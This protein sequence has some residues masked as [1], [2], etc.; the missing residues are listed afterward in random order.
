MKV[1]VRL[2]SFRGPRGAVPSI[3]EVPAGTT[4]SQLLNVLRAG[5]EA[6]AAA[7]IRAVVLVNQRQVELEAA[8]QDG[9][10]VA[11]YPVL[12]GGA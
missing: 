6:A 12:G 2:F 5:D 11:I 7:I 9:D 4:V 3:V 8:L 1:K 10:E